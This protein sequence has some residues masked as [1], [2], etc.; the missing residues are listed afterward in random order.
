MVTDRQEVTLM[1][2]KLFCYFKIER[3]SSISLAL[4]IIQT[5]RASCSTI[6]VIYIS[7]NQRS[8]RTFKNRVLS[9]MTSQ[10]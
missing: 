1:S 3:L 7:G 4:A 8:N 10:V 9:I 2:K 5:V 6:Y